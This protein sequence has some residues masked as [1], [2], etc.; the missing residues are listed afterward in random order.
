LTI[1]DSKETPIMQLCDLLTGA[2]VAAYNGVNVDSP[3]YEMANYI[4]GKCGRDDL[5]FATNKDE[6]KLNI[7]RIGLN[8]R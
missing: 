8:G 5:I 2:V 6:K 1:V 3:K 7:F 4:A